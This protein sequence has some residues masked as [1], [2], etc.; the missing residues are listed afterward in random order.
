MIDP[1]IIRAIQQRPLA[2]IRSIFRRS[3]NIRLSPLTISRV[4]NSFLR[5]KLSSPCTAALKVH[6]VAAGKAGGI[7]LLQGCPSRLRRK[8]IVLIAAVVGHIIGRSFTNQFIGVHKDCLFRQFCFCK[9]C[10]IFLR[11]FSGFRY[12][13]RS[14]VVQTHDRCNGVLAG[15]SIIQ[16][17]IQFVV[18]I[19]KMNTLTKIHTAL[20][21][22]Y[23]RKDYVA[24]GVFLSAH[25][26]KVHRNFTNCITVRVVPGKL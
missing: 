25:F 18:T 2:C 26:R 22:V 17:K 7:Y 1:D 19:Q 12:I 10:F 9:N 23:S 21:P 5:P 13:E 11:D 20:H 6:A 16:V 14:R 4:N 15:E 3:K 8:T 24:N